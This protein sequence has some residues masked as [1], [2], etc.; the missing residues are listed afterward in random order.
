[1]ETL[2]FVHIIVLVVLSWHVQG[3]RIPRIGEARNAYKSFGWRY[4][5]ERNHFI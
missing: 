4:H 5:L 3:Y 1:M 2:S